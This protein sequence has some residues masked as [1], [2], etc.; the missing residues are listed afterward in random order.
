[1]ASHNA[2]VLAMPKRAAET[3]LSRHAVDADYIL[4]IVQ[5]LTHEVKTYLHYRNDGDVEE[6]LVC[7]QSIIATLKTVVQLMFNFGTNTTPEYCSEECTKFKTYLKGAYDLLNQSI[8]DFKGEN[9][10]VGSGDV[11]SQGDQ[12]MF[13]ILHC[14]RA[15]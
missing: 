2:F 10:F 7:R 4:D 14:L 3:M 12:K 5:R 8:V 6:Q 1:M 11:I 15:M 13:Q 9:V